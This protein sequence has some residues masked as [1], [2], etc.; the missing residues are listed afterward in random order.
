MVEGFQIGPLTVR[1]YGLILMSGVV[2][3][4]V[5]SYFTAKRR[6]LD[7]EIVIDSLTWVVI[8]G[9]IGARIWHTVRAGE[10]VVLR[11]CAT[12]RATSDPERLVPR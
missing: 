10:I 1:F 4:A 2:A 9:V 8:G 6:E 3:A 12:S 7:T 11:S 5:L